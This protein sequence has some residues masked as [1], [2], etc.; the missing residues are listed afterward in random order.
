MIKLLKTI[1]FLFIIWALGLVYFFSKIEDKS[2]V[3][4]EN[5]DA[6]IV[7]TGGKNR[8][9]E[10]VKLLQD[11]KSGRL[12]ITGVDKDVMDWELLELLG[13]EAW[14]EAKIE[15]GYEATDTFGNVTEAK[16]WIAENEIKSI[17][18][19]TANYH[20]PRANALFA[21][22]L[23]DI[24]IVQYPSISPQVELRGWLGDERV[25]G[26]IISEYNKYLLSF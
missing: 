17:I 13:V 25:R 7:L 23:P 1:V 16:K 21:K 5:A 20:M 9:E 11:G 22:A 26:I 24:E 4:V 3:S 10:A 18:L 2:P 15:L 8:I 12:F 6:I 14:D 19:V